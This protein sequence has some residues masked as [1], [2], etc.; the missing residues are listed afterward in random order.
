[1]LFELG[2]PLD[3][4]G[5]MLLDEFSGQLLSMTQIYERHHIDRRFIKTNY[6]E[7]LKQLEQEGKI[8]ASPAACERK[9]NTFADRVM[10]KFPTKG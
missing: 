7:V 2:R 5:S 3:E 8:V 1:M 4:L 9:K 6:K 10:V